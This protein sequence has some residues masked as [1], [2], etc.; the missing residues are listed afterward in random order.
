MAPRRL[1]TIA[2]AALLAL[3]VGSC[4]ENPATAPGLDSE[5]LV[6]EAGPLGTAPVDPTQPWRWA[7][8]SI[9]SLVFEDDV[10]STRIEVTD[11][12]VLDADGVE[13]AGTVRWMPGN[14]YI[15][16]TE[17]FPSTAVDFVI[18]NPPARSTLGKI[19]FIPSAPLAENSVYTVVYSGGIRMEKGQLRR[20]T[21][22]WSY[23][24][25]TGTP[26]S[27]PPPAATRE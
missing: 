2:L 18:K 13:V 14:A 15:L 23:R 22:S 17:P 8:N 20:D 16:Y 9:D 7:V 24:T 11:L 1:S 6:K 26:P 19:Y 10:D 21:F 27:P 3:A 4:S 25:G 12:R 5:I